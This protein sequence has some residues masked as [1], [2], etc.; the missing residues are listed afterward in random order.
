MKDFLGKE[1][2]LGDTVILIA[3]NYRHLVKAKIYAF[4]PKHVRVE[5][6]NTWNYGHPGFVKQFLQSPS[7]LIK[8]DE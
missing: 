2:S 7:Q 1:L 4:T 5:F 8:V 6:Y 3:P